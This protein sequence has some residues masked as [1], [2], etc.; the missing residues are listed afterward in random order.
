MKWGGVSPLSVVALKILKN[1]CRPGE[2][3]RKT[4]S[5]CKIPTLDRGNFA[6]DRHQHSRGGLSK[7][8]ID[9]CHLCEYFAQALKKAPLQNKPSYFGRV[10]ALAKQAQLQTVSQ[11]FQKWE[12][13]HPSRKRT[14]PCALA[15]TP[16]KTD[17]DSLTIPLPSHSSCP[18]SQDGLKAPTGVSFKNGSKSRRPAGNWSM[19]TPC[20]LPGLPG[21]INDGRTTD[22]SIHRMSESLTFTCTRG[23]PAL[24]IS[25]FQKRHN[26][27]SF[28]LGDLPA[29]AH[30]CL[31][32][33]LV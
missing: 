33:L 27:V 14:L 30:R 5:L 13:P 23:N 29:V 3:Y 19:Q 11:R 31:S 22:S 32:C 21:K 25:R 12:E 16:S 28:F 1:N 17:P 18:L 10:Q 2:T 8:L 6:E 4:P 9:F 15:S 24:V 26:L 20:S 7:Y